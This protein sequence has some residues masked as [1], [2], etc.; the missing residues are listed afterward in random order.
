VE[1]HVYTSAVVRRLKNFTNIFNVYEIT[2][3]YDISTLIKVKDTADLNNMI[4]ALRAIPGIKQTDTRIVLKKHRD[5]STG[6][7]DNSSRIPLHLQQDQESAW[8]H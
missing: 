7:A 1:S 5:G 6:Q 4:E 8:A 3:D 2:G